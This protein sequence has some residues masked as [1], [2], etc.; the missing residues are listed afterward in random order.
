MTRSAPL[1][2]ILRDLMLPRLFI[3]TPILQKQAKTVLHD[4]GEQQPQP[5]GRRLPPGY[6][7]HLTAT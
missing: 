6:R 4:D 7:P 1:H 2:A 5:I 3:E